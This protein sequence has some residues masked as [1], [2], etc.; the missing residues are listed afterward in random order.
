MCL[1]RRFT[2]IFMLGVATSFTEISAQDLIGTTGLMNIPTADMQ[3]DGTFDGGA[4]WVTQTALHDLVNFDTGIYY[5]RFTPFS[6][7]EFT[8]RETLF[9]TQHS[10]KKTWNY[11][12][13]DRSST[14]R[15]RP[16]AERR[17]K[18]WPSIVFGAND[19]YS[20]YGNSFYAGYYGVATKHFPLGSGHVSLSA[21]YFHPVKAGKM[22]NGAFAGVEYRP[23]H[24]IP[25][26]LMADY[27]TKGV[28]LGLSYTFMGHLRTF[29]FTHQLKGWGVGL[30][31]CTTIKY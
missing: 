30:S 17:G 14:I 19:L 5:V 12:Q 27:D 7:F 10:V 18:W 21:G 15:I 23:M 4:R 20:A 31:Y 13:Q 9:K 11:Y 24:K 3:P 16:L 1:F 25:L 6:F 26:L 22:Y 8:F 2:L 28:N 29:A